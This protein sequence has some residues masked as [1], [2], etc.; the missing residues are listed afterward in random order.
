VAIAAKSRAIAAKT[1]AEA[2]DAGSSYA[3]LRRVIVN[4]RQ[5]KAQLSKL[6]AAA[7][8]GEVVVITR[9]AEP[10]V[11]L[12]PVAPMRK[13]AVPGKYR[14]LFELTDAFF[15]PLPEDELALWNG[16]GD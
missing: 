7:L 10:I 13:T 1:R 14:G 15:G 3:Q 11:R 5:A 4:V 8:A 6:I 9:H 16:E 2:V 12:T